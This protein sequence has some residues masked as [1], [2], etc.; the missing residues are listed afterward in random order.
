MSRN[1]KIILG[2]AAAG[3]LLCACG[4]IATFGA[5]GSFGYALLR[6]NEPGPAQVGSVAS[7]IADFQVPAGYQPEAVAELAGILLVSYAP[8]DGHSHIMFVQAP[9]SLPVDQATLE[10]YAQEAA[11]K[12]GYDR[13]TRSKIVGQKQATIRGQ[14]VTLVIGEGTNSEGQ[15]YRTLTGVFQG[16]GG[17]ALVSVEQPVS[18][19]NQSTV[20]EFIA[21]IR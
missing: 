11:P 14:A 21:S 13:N 7:R 2:I 19:W 20:D 6:A 12:R 10:Q 3:L 18:R 17:P 8:G 16:K 4:A 9:A 15:A 5:L 1:A